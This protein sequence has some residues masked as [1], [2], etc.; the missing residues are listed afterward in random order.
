MRSGRTR[1]DPPDGSSRSASSDSKLLRSLVQQ[2][3]RLSGEDLGLRRVRRPCPICSLAIDHPRDAEAVDDHAE[4]LR[5]ERLLERGKYAA[6]CGQIV[7][8]AVSIVRAL[9]VERE[10]ETFRLLVAAR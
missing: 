9:Q 5:P 2:K 1:S 7:E 8:D 3:C 10:R 6:A 4:P